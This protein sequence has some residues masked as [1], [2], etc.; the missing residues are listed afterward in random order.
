MQ[1]PH[2]WTQSEITALPAYELGW[3]YG[4]VERKFLVNPLV[5]TP[6]IVLS[7]IFPGQDAYAINEDEITNDWPKVI[8]D[9][10]RYS[11]DYF[12]R[13]LRHAA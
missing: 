5:D 3:F 9:V 1:V 2:V 6:V 13:Y 4:L 7:E 11:P 10:M 12:E 8:E